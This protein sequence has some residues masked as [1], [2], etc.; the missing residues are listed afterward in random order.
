M[1][2]LMRSIYKNLFLM[3]VGGAIYAAIEIFYRG[4]THWS[5]IL[6]GGICFL[7]IGSINEYISWEMPLI[8]QMTIS[9]LIVTAIEFV[10]GVIIN[11]VFKMNV[12][13][14][15]NL[16]F[17]ILGQICVPFMFLWFLISIVA[18]ILDDYLRYW[19]L[20]EEKPHYIWR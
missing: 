12:W 20:D 5:M 10:S 7:S 14:Y 2:S 19:F 1:K 11:I 18:I 15:S 17:N 4:Y 13:D 8:L 3:L 6:V 9:M 16:P